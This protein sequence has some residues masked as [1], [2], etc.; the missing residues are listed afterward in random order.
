MR[1]LIFGAMPPSR[2]GIETL[3]ESLVPALAARGHHVTVISESAIPFEEDRAGVKVV[4][5]SMFDAVRTNDIDAVSA[6]SAR[7]RDIVRTCAPDIIH[8]NPSGPELLIVTL[9][10]KVF[11]NIPV[12]LTVHSIGSTDGPHQTLRK[13][14]RQSSVVTGVSGVIVEALKDHGQESEL[15]ENALPA[16]GPM[17]TFPSEP[18]V[19]ALGRIVVEKGFDTLIAAMS[20]VQKTHIEAT[21]TIA[22]TGPELAGLRAKARSSFPNSDGFHTPGWISGAAKEELL[23][24]SQ[25]V[26][27]PSRW[28]EPFG[29]VALE[30][31]QAGRPVVTTHSGELPRIVSDGQTGIVVPIGDPVAMAGA[32]QNL[33]VNPE[34]AAGMGRNAYAM[35]Q[36][37]YDFGLMVDGYEKSYARAIRRKH[38]NT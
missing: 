23:A 8:L 13:L 25:I 32:I 29:L 12:L 24:A 33:L 22:G 21:L 35:V 5:I 6:H 11:R 9:A 4:G 19:L 34:K 10:L 18:S 27:I 30:A 15:I 7:I 26:V 1:I 17:S 37:R 3:L 31:A 2:G 38:S 14:M 16:A 36:K 28:Q 20:I